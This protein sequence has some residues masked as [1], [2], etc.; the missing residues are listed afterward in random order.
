LP[1]DSAKAIYQSFTPRIQKRI[2][3]A[4]IAGLF[5]NSEQNVVGNTPYNFKVRDILG[6]QIS[7][8]KF[9]GKFLYIDFWAS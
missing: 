4:F 2:N 5:A 8:S 3:G 7:L 6:N 9:A 1:I